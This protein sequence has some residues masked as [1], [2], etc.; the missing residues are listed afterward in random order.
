MSMGGVP[1][2]EPGRDS[3]TAL[4]PKGRKKRKRFLV[5]GLVLLTALGYLIY[6]AVASNSEYY[7]T[8]GEVYAMGAQ[9]RESQIKIGGRVVEGSIAWDRGSGS[10]RFTI[11]DERGHTMPVSYRGVVPD[12]FQPGAEVILE[13]KL[14]QDGGFVATALLAKCASKYEPQIPE[15]GK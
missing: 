14:G 7:L 6:S 12:S 4:R 10:V 15:V 5:A 13:G 1:V 3:R 9:A 8:V 11:G 2:A